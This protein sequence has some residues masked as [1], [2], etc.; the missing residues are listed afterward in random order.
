ML[1]GVKTSAF[2]LEGSVSLEIRVSDPL[3]ITSVRVGSRSKRGGPLDALVF[4]LPD[5][6]LYLKMQNLLNYFLDCVNRVSGADN[7]SDSVMHLGRCI[8]LIKASKKDSADFLSDEINRLLCEFL[9]EA[10]LF[11]SLTH[12]FLTNSLPQTDLS[13]LPTDILIVAKSS[14]LQWLSVCILEEL[15]KPFAKNFE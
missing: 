6:S 15:K 8:E 14:N 9:D 7:K 4:N 5:L 11:N 12:A 10:E 13:G 1:F 3:N 2:F